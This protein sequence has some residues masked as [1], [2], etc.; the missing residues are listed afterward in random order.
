MLNTSTVEYKHSKED[1]KQII[2]NSRIARSGIL[3]RIK[4]TQWHI[5]NSL[6]TKTK[7]INVINLASLLA[8]F[9]RMGIY[10]YEI[11]QTEIAEKMA[12]LFEMENVPARNTIS[13]WEK[14][15]AKIGLL[16]IPRHVDWGSRKTKLRL[17]THKFW[18]LSRQGLE[19][20]SYECPHVTFCAGRV[21]R[22]KPV[23]P[24]D[25]NISNKYVTKIRARETEIKQPVQSRTKSSQNKFSRPPKNQKTIPKKLSKF[26]NSICWWLFQNRNLH[27]Y[28]EGILIFAEF[29]GLPSR[30]DYRE[31]LQRAWNDCRDAERPGLVTDLIRNMR[32]GLPATAKTEAGQSAI[33]PLQ[34]VAAAPPKNEN[35]EMAMLRNAL[36][37]GMPYAGNYPDLVAEFKTAAPYR[38]DEILENLGRGKIG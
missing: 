25:P 14:E 16:E 30:D 12:E 11:T 36:L 10:A 18:D 23:I 7:N 27:S 22:V 32:A 2:S 26:E 15:L 17:I 34:I 33:P 31:G 8:V 24:E 1:R 5:F 38:Q 6:R 3:P 19:K 29:L 20:M 28:R 37:F 35:P 21:E 4:Y 9:P 13:T